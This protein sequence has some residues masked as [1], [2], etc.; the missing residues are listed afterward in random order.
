MLE[1]QRPTRESS[2]PGGSDD[3]FSG[4][5]VGGMVTCSHGPYSEQLPVGHTTVAEIRTRY[6]DRFDID[7]QST[8]VINGNPA[9]DDTIVLPGQML[10]FT[11]KAGEKGMGTGYCNGG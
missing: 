3:I 10:M 7:P 8:A 2:G 11:R 4:N 1:Q 9:T 6:R 5:S